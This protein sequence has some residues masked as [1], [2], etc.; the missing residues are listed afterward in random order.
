[1]AD[2]ACACCQGARAP[3]IHLEEEG[4]PQNLVICLR[5]LRSAMLMQA[6]ST[7]PRGGRLLRQYADEY[8]LRLWRSGHAIYLLPAM[9]PF[10]ADAVPI[11]A[12]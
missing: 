12:Q 10:A 9:P 6:A 3:R 1:M 4:G 11:A 7:E 8:G 2:P 5:C